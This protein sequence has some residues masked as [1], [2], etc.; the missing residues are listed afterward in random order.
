[1]NHTNL[2]TVIPFYNRR[3]TVLAALASVAAQ[4]KP[5][6][7]LIV[8]DDGSTDGGSE[9]VRAWIS[10]HGD[11]AGWQ[12]I[13]QGNAGV[14]A[15]RNRALAHAGDDDFIAFLDSDDVWPTDFLERMSSRLSDDPTAVA[16]SC[17]RRFVFADGSP[18]RLHDSSGIEHCAALWMLEHGANLASCTLF[19]SGP[20]KQQGGFD[21]RLRTGEDSALFMPLSL[22]G[23]WLHAPGEAVQYRHG[24]AAHIGEEG[25]L[26]FRYKDNRRIWATQYELFFVRGKGQELLTQAGCHKMLARAWYQAGREL[27]DRN[28][29]REA[30]YCFRK[31]VA[32][33]PWRVKYYRSLLR[34]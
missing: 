10:S 6:D 23:A 4:T 22:E 27:V 31:A 5:T 18:E 29:S 28:A 32:W 2:V 21:E 30:A 26:S 20:I 12:L 25:N 3:R 9:V 7:R 34:A 13:V 15:A 33:N 8:V 16:V 19:R 17:D 1:M 24:E 14:S 11:P